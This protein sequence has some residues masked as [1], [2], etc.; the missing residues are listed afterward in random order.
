MHGVDNFMGAMIDEEMKTLSPFFFLPLMR[1]YFY[2]F[3]PEILKHQNHFEKCKFKAKIQLLQYYL[4]THFRYQRI[5]YLTK[6]WFSLSFY[7]YQNFIST[8]RY[9]VFVF[10][11][12]KLLKQAIL[13]RNKVK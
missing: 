9:F 4:V 13:I 10:I 6:K 12:N 7:G 5:E 1:W 11:T 2:Y 3:T 8:S